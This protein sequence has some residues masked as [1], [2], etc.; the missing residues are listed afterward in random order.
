MEN[1]LQIL[2]L[3][4]DAPPKDPPGPK[5]LLERQARYR[6]F[7]SNLA[8]TLLGQP[9]ALVATTSEPAEFWP[10]VFVY[11]GISGWA[12]LE[13]AL[14]HM[15]AVVILLSL[16]RS[17]SREKIEFQPFDHSSYLTYSPPS[18]TFPAREARRPS[19]SVRSSLA[20]KPAV[21]AAMKV[22]RQTQGEN[23]A[24]IVPPDVAQL[25]K[26][27]DLPSAA[28]ASPVAPAVPIAATTAAG[29][30][31]LAGT[32]AVVGPPPD[33][34]QA[35]LRG[36][37]A[38]QV[39]VVAPQ[40]EVQT[41]S[42]RRGTGGPGRIEVVAPAP[43]LP[44]HQARGGSGGTQAALQ[45]TGESIVPPPPSV[46]RS[47]NIGRGPGGGGLAGSSGLTAVPPAPSFQDAIGSTG[48]GSGG[49]PGSSGFAAVPPPPSIDGA[50]AA[51]ARGGNGLSGGSGLAVVAPAPGLPMGAGGGSGRG[52]GLG[53]GGGSGLGIV[54]PAPSVQGTG[55]GMG[56]PGAGLGGRGSGLSVVPPAPSV[57]GGGR[58][59]G[60]GGAGMGGG[61][62][63]SAVPPAPSVAGGGLSAGLGG[64]G[65]GGG[66]GSGEGSGFG[67]V[68]PAP[69]VE[70]SGGA[71]GGGRGGGSGFGDGFGL[72]AV[73]PAPS[74]GGGTGSSGRGGMLADSSPPVVPPP[75]STD[76]TTNPSAD[77]GLQTAVEELHMR[78][79]GLAF[80]LPSTSFS[81][82]YEV[83]I[84]E[85][86]LASHT[87]QLI[88]LVYWFLP[89]QRRLTEY[90]PDY[91]K[92][93]KLRAT[94]DK[95]C[96]ESLV[97]MTVSATGQ[98]FSSAQ[99]STLS[100]GFPSGN[101]DVVL[102]CYRTTADDYRKA[103]SRGH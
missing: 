13:S 19:T 17:M 74:M 30:K 93:Y 64:L 85:R 69:S 55:G 31:G 52:G 39:T 95:A 67:A 89:Y 57:A 91:T 12:L 101:R 35:G 81:S 53:F 9:A 38:M 2:D 82:T 75:P 3:E 15:V 60:L 4:T 11:S 70:G 103:L 50:G 90:H 94:R 56:R 34:M 84:A 5:L 51:T 42:T 54:P 7:C 29:L 61:S 49:L 88:K 48:H 23:H 83:F 43:D 100:P 25:T 72:S 37:N 63:L 16:P 78:I 14:W 73:P 1:G 41:A 98:S 26:R 28:I 40:P 6:T 36:Q 58:S 102:P 22:V 62:G 92:M 44:L 18:P 46:S 86:Q 45:G 77:P 20:R 68:P 76:D 79:V 87:I 32:A 8:Y 21:P 96:D 59:A 24:L 99:L 97:H 71:G 47:G 65:L 33:A 80:A 66:L 27:S 10:D